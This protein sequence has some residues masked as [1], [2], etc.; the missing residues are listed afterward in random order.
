V[1]ADVAVMLADGGEA[2]A[3]I[4]V[5]RHQ[6]EV[7]GPVASPPTVWRTLGEVTPGRLKMIATARARVRRH[8][9]AQLDARDGIPASKVAGIDLGET[10]VLDV[11]ATIVIA[12]SEKENASPTFKKT[13][14]F[15]PLGV[16]C[17]T[18]KRSSPRCCAPGGPAPPRP[19]ITSRC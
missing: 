7:L 11:D 16:W 3:D 13:C 6:T 15:H 19:R 17:D 8:V 4:E 12:H 1:L 9:W 18:P 10:V 2:I 5:L 14:G